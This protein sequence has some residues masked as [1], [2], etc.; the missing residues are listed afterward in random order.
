MED[1]FLGVPLTNDFPDIGE[2]FM[3]ATTERHTE[4]D[5]DDLAVALKAFHDGTSNWFAGGEL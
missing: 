5:L 2:A 1:I 4:A 3:L